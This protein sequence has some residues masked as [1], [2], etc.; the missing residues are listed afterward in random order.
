MYLLIACASSWLVLLGGYAVAWTRLSAPWTTADLLVLILAGTA[1]LAFTRIGLVSLFSLSLRLLPHG[2]LRRRLSAMLLRF[3]PLLLRSSVA[4][5]VSA[6]L[7]AQAGHALPHPSTAAASLT[8]E[9]YW[10]S[11]ASPPDP[12]WPTTPAEAANEEDERTAPAETEESGDTEPD[13]P[14]D[15]A[16]PT[17]PPRSGDTGGHSDGGEDSAERDSGDEDSAERDADGDTA[18]GPAA[19]RA[20]G[21]VDGPV[22]GPAAAGTYTV[23]SGDS[24]WSIALA[25]AEDSSTAAA[26]VREIHA[27]NRDTI[28]PDPNLIMPGQRLEIQP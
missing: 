8:S 20:E 1:A 23:R 28:G 5:V 22:D 18:E 9:P 24:L 2:R 12:G 26:L 7:V 16:W 25:H 3:G 4:A 11:A 19:G 10:S 17:A 6:G 13:P 14:L 27:D 21:P 15:P